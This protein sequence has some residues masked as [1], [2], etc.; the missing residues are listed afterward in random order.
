M[1]RQ[2]WETNALDAA[3][4]FFQS[5]YYHLPNYALAVLMYAAIGR[6][7]L[8]LFVDPNWNNFIWRGFVA[9]SDPAVK[10]VRAITPDAVPPPVIIIF[11]V[12]WLI[13]ARVLLFFEFAR[14]GLAP[15]VF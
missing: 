12:L 4:S 2:S 8:S 6:F 5:W 3:T 7:F 13:A 1:S 11:T 10:L 15:R 9:V 14:W